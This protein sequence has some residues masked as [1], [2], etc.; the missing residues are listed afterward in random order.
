[1]GWTSIHYESRPP[2]HERNSLVKQWMESDTCHIIDR[3][4]W[5]D[6][7]RRQF[8]LMEADSPKKGIT[9]RR[10]VIMMIVEH[11]RGELFY[12]AIDE[13]MGPLQYDCPMR[14]MKRL[15]GHAPIGEFS[16][17][18]RQKVLRH[19]QDTRPRDAI[20]RKLRKNYPKGARRL[21]LNE[22]PQVEYCQGDHRGRKSVSAYHDPSS[23]K[24]YLLRPH[25]ID[26]DATSTLWTTQEEPHQQPAPVC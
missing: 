8:L 14:I 24:L 7:G 15:E 18:W 16:G 10:F 17:Q 3:S 12:K 1:M 9:G 6:H 11:R 22:G 19:H 13:S 25:M 4:A 23:G 20:L 2:S 5:M 21:V 26:A